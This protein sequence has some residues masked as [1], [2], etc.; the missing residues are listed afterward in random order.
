MRRLLKCYLLYLD[1]YKSELEDQ[2]L[3]KEAGNGFSSRYH[4]QVLDRD[5]LEAWKWAPML[6]DDALTLMIKR[7]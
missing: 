3:L 7:V 1:V 5:I 2:Y 4:K 6:T